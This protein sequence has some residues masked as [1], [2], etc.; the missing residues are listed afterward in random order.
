MM[1]EVNLPAMATRR[2]QEAGGR[3]QADFYSKK[4]FYRMIEMVVKGEREGEGDDFPS[5]YR[6]RA[7]ASYHLAPQITS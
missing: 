3:G 2:R 1:E 7:S 4:K 6:R 5:R